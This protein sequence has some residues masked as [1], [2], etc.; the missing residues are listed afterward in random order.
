MILHQY[1]IRRV[2]PPH[3]QR[4]YYHHYL[5]VKYPRLWGKRYRSYLSIKELE[6]EVYILHIENIEQ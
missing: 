5:K 2:Y 6:K 4:R 3:M 1:R